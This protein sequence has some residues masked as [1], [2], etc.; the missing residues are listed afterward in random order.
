MGGGEGGGCW[1][2]LVVEVVVFGGSGGGG[3]WRMEVVS[4]R[5]I[6]SLD[7]HIALASAGLK[8]DSNVLINRAQ[9]KCQSHMH[10]AKDPI[11]MEYIT[12][13]IAGLQ[14]K[15]KQ[16]GG[17]RLV[18]LSTLDVGFDPYTDV[19]SLYQTDP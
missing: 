7:H 8:A 2:W 14:R 6:I 12:R 1:W 4:V 3:W 15:Y 18:G 13:Y 5:K 17:V 11:I 19:P 16:S 10:I 9:I